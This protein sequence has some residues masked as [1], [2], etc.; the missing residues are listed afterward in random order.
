MF[1]GLHGPDPVAHTARF[2]H[3]SSP[4]PFQPHPSA[5]DTAR[6]QHVSSPCPFQPPSL[7]QRHRPLS[8]RVKSV[9]IP[10]PSLRQ[11]QRSSVA[12]QTAFSISHL[13]TPPPLHHP[14]PHPADNPARRRRACGSF[15]KSPSTEQGRT[16]SGRDC[17]LLLG[18]GAAR[19]LLLAAS[20]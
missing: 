13:P 1:S 5:S 4:C 16:I 11:C 7:R 3:V 12:S 10:T 18:T 17:R 19:L 2:Q 9:P 8:T 6:F 15:I 20:N 14:A